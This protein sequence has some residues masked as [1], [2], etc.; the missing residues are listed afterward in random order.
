MRF[1]MI[2]CMIFAGLFLAIIAM[3]K[4][5]VFK[6]ST[7]STSPPPVTTVPKIDTEPE[8]M[9]QTSFGIGCGMVAL[10]V[11]LSIQ[12]PWADHVVAFL[13]FACAGGIIAILVLRM[14]YLIQDEDKVW[15]YLLLIPC[16]VNV[17]VMFASVGAGMSSK[18]FQ[19]RFLPPHVDPI[20]EQQTRDNWTKISNDLQSQLPSILG[21]VNDVIFLSPTNTKLRLEILFG[22]LKETGKKVW[23]S[24]F[25]HTQNDV[26]I[27]GKGLNNKVAKSDNDNLV[28]KYSSSMER[29]TLLI[30]ALHEL[31]VMLFVFPDLLDSV[32][33]CNAVWD[34]VDKITRCAPLTSSLSAIDTD[35]LNIDELVADLESGKKILIPK[36]KRVP[37]K[38][39]GAIVQEKCEL[40]GPDRN[41]LLDILVKPLK[42]VEELEKMGFEHGDLHLGNVMYD[43]ANAHIQFLDFAD[44][45]VLIEW[46]GKKYALL[47]RAPDEDV[48][49]YKRS[50]RNSCPTLYPQLIDR[51]NDIKNQLNTPH[52]I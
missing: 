26:E 30:F 23:K 12:K 35:T 28:F 34:D 25:E 17:V 3:F 32:V 51:M 5:G 49:K 21:K 8:W 42:V 44:S 27:I 43:E 20:A 33:I 36:M 2:L 1:A 46:H 9:R 22:K 45:A 47:S 10:G 4:L 14:P 19:T 24:D 7:A 18:E 16:L 50:V 15:N 39:L 31:L 6:S 11:L 38:T 29:Y 13:A 41:K 52:T 37:G 40:D 48:D